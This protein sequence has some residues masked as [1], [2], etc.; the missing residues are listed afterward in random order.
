[1][2]EKIE[3]QEQKI[4]KMKEKIK[5]LESEIEENKKNYASEQNARKI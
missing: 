3:S 4:L 5:N 2:E 1:M